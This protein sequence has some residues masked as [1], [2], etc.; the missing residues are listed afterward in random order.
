MREKLS[1]NKILSN[2]KLMIACSIILGIIIWAVVIYGPSVTEEKSITVPITVR[3]NTSAEQG[4]NLPG[5]YFQVLS[6]S[7]D[8]VEV[9][10]SGNRSVISRLQAEDIVVSAD[11]SDVLQAVDD[12]SVELRA[13]KNPSSAISDY[14][15]EELKT[16]QIRVTCDYVGET[17]YAVE[18]DISTVKV[19]DDTKYQLGTP[20]LD[21]QLFPNESVTVSG[22]KKVRDR[23]AKIVAKVNSTEAVSDST[24]FEAKLMAYDSDGEQVD[25]SQCTFPD[26]MEQEDPTTAQVTVPVNY[27]CNVKLGIDAINM[28][29]AFEG[30]EDFITLSPT[31][32]DLLGQEE[33]VLR[34]VEELQAIPLNFDNVPYTTGTISL[35]LNI[36]SHVT[37]ADNLTTVEV[38]IDMEGFTN[39]RISVPLFR[40]DG[41]TLAS[42][43]T[44]QNQPEGSDITLT[45]KNL[46]VTVVGSEEDVAELEASD[47]RVT[48]DMAEAT[49]SGNLSVY[50]A[51]ITI[52]GKNNMWVYYGED[53]QDSLSVYVTSG[54]TS[55]TSS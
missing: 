53:P 4:E 54:T 48:I 26:L 49:S 40:S 17:N 20:V 47:L 36:P 55:T 7:E 5:Q 41:E 35:P 46:T 37:V 34:L 18:K 12:Y 50:P 51:R 15:I 2:D 44:I 19:T 32:L 42:N 38:K 3:L 16:R 33:E 9:I 52:P 25:L 14:T 13:S 29:S 24:V 1:F 10:V 8:S 30:R 28:P 23:I 22:P 43:V 21:S 27:F 6:K 11:L 45:T 39:Q 31:S